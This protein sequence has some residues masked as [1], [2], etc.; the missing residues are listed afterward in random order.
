MCV[1]G[2]P[3]LSLKIDLRPHYEN[4]PHLRDLFCSTLGIKGPVWEDLVKGLEVLTWKMETTGHQVEAFYS[5]MFNNPM[6]STTE[7]IR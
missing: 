7:E 2:G 5:Y 4:I 1:W 3:P 6:T